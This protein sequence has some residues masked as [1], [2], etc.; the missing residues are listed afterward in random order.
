MGVKVTPNV[1]PTLNPTIQL[2]FFCAGVY[3][4][5]T[6]KG[7]PEGYIAQGRPD[8]KSNFECFGI[9]C[10]LSPQESKVR[11]KWKCG[12]SI[13]PDS[14]VRVEGGGYIGNLDFVTFVN[15]LPIR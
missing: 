11:R 14:F 15:H 10:A 4:A 13:Q 2:F 9:P 6:Q 7:S 3:I 8:L 1:A 12:G 5:L